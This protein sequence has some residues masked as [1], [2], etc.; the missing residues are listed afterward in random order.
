MT[1]EMGRRPAFCLDY[2]T[3]MHANAIT[4]PEIVLSRGLSVNSRG[5]YYHVTAPPMPVA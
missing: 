4:F 2:M 3:S 1:Y 5:G